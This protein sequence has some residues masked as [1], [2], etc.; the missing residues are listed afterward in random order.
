MSSGRQDD[1]PDPVPGGVSERGGDEGLLTSED[2]FG[3]LVDAGSEPA[4][5]RPSEPRKAP[6]RVQVPE[7]GAARRPERAPMP[8]DVRPED[9]AALLDA[10]SDASGEAAFADVPPAVFSEEPVERAPAPE[11]VIS[12]EPDSVEDLLGELPL[13]ED[14]PVVASPEPEAELL[15]DP[16]EE[17]TVLE[18][19][20][21]EEPVPQPVLRDAESPELAL[22]EPL[23]DVASLLSPAE[24]PEPELD[25]A[26]AEV[27]ETEDLPDLDLPLT[28]EEEPEAP[29]AA[30]SA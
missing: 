30:A 22:D 16:F 2:L 18:E 5:P 29:V 15:L 28:L 19:P 8:K 10:F 27:I 21:L 12:F 25:A 17:A 1:L 23:D 3:D 26:A 20:V 6:V 4:A 14:A 24:E 9:M 11:P 7:P 13:G